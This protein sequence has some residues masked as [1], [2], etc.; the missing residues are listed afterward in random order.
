HR[1][2][3][4]AER[5]RVAVHLNSDRDGMDVVVFRGVAEVARDLPPA[6]RNDAYLAK[7]RAAMQR[8]S[9]DVER[10]AATYSVPLRVRLERLRGF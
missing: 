8:I 3:H 9:G 4:I 1:L 6:D 10:F 5:P 7:Y 2:E